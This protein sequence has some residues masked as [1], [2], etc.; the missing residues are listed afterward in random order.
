L[1]RDSFRESS[2]HLGEI[3][4][5]GNRFERPGRG[6]FPSTVIVVALLFF[7][8]VRFSSYSF[9][10]PGM[11]RESNQRRKASLSTRRASLFHKLQRIS[12]AW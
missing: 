1:F 10:G 5:M 7:L 6:V 3:I 4:F 8:R 12:I 2:S 11:P 9:L